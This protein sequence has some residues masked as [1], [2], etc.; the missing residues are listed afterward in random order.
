MLGRPARPVATLKARAIRHLARREHSR[1][2]LRR[3]L[4]AEAQAEDEQALDTLLDELEAKSLLSDE[5]FT[6]VVVRGSAMR[7]GVA[8]IARKLEEAGVAAS[9]SAP[10]LERLKAHEPDLAFDLWSRRFG[11]LPRTPQE[12]ARQFRF[13]LGRGFGPQAV[14]QVWR[15]AVRCTDDDGAY[16]LSLDDLLSE[17]AS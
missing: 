9:V 13:L 6:E 7:H 8:R 15:R 16:R 5:R 10:R 2:E 3:K 4:S 1:A 17:E 12:K 11:Q 14:H